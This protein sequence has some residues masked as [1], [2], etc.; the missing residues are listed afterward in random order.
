MGITVSSD[1]TQND[2]VDTFMR[3]ADIIGVKA[4]TPEQ[5]E[6]NRTTGRGPTRPR[7]AK[8]GMVPVTYPTLWRWVRDGN[9]PAPVRLSPSGPPF[10]RA[11]DI[12][13][14]QKSRGSK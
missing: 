8:K 1:I 7:P 13:A 9:F 6:V 14:W 10:W 12:L 4:V 3:T 11:S 2:G 5:A